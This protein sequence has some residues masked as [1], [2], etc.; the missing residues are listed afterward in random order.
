MTTAAPPVVQPVTPFAL[1]ETRDG[2]TRVLRLQAFNGK[3]PLLP[4]EKGLEWLPWVD[5]PRPDYNPATHALRELDVDTLSGRAQRVW[6]VYPLPDEV[7]AAN[8]R[9]EVPAVVTMRQAR[10]ALHRA[11]LLTRV[12][13]ALAALPEPTRTEAQIEWEYATEAQRHYGLVQA[14]GPALG[15]GDEQLDALFSAASLL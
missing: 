4:A 3:P 2:A 8:L 15:L 10:L 11:G 13:A 1:V 7:A 9:G 14:L 5:T 12:N 6:E